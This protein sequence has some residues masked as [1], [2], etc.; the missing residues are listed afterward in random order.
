LAG[1]FGKLYVFRAAVEAG[2]YGLAIAGVLASVVSAFYYLSIVRLMY[3]EE[4]VEVL[5]RPLGGTL[6]F[7]ITA[8]ALF[9]FF[10]LGALGPVG[11]SA[12]LAAQSLFA[13]GR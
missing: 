6:A 8:A 2:L 9:V 13:T 7:V 12:A 3:F 4:P 5:D 10:F 11:D 1:F